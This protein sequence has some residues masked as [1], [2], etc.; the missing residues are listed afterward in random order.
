MSD[1]QSNA[2]VV[3]ANALFYFKQNHHNAFEF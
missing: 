3:S 1:S 2:T